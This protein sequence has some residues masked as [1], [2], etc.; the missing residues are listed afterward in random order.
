MSTQTLPP[1]F[2]GWFIPPDRLDPATLEPAY[3]FDALLD[4][5]RAAS[6]DALSELTPS[7][8]DI[9]EA[10]TAATET[11][12]PLRLEV[13]YQ[14]DKTVRANGVLMTPPITADYWT[15]RVRL[16]ARQA[17]VGFPKFSTI[18]IGFAL[19][20]DWNTNLPYTRGAEEIFKHIA[21]NKGDEA[22]TR[23]D[24]LDAIRM[25]QDAAR[26]EMVTV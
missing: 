13:R 25:I 1:Y 2:N 6:P 7:T 11:L 21:H 15:F 10:S 22:I 26:A 3:L 4:E 20:E 23:E 12:R 18:G 24:C 17:I 19:E 9:A 5:T 8:T 16:T 14:A